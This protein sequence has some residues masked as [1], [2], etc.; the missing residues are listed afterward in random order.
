MSLRVS[1]LYSTTTEDSRSK[2]NVLGR[3]DD[4]RVKIAETVVSAA[5]P[6]D[7]PDDT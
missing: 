7:I 3:C 1:N 4:E 6:V 2:A 5:V